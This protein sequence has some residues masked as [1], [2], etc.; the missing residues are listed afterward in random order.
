MSFNKSL[1][2]G[3]SRGTFLTAFQL[4]RWS[5][6]T[7]LASL[8]RERAE[9][10]L[11]PH[12]NLCQGSPRSWIGVWGQGLPLGP[13][14]GDTLSVS[15]AAPAGPSPPPRLLFPTPAPAGWPHPRVPPGTAT[16]TT[17]RPGRPKPQ[18]ERFSSGTSGQAAGW[19]PHPTLT[20]S[21]EICGWQRQ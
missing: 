21:A 5:K 3:H 16:G 14:V 15:P 18:P 1:P 2:K 17:S 6:R 7:F 20:I 4:R 12:S 9:A 10:R 8:A 13:A 19:S 11:C